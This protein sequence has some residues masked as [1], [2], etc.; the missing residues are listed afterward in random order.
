MRSRS[1]FTLI[2]LLVVMV[3]ISI[4]SAFLLPALGGA[5]ERARRT[6]CA[7]NLKQIGVALHSYSADFNEAYPA[8]LGALFPNY[9]DD[10]RVFDCPSTSTTGSESSPEFTYTQPSPTTA[11]NVVV[12][13]DAS[14]N[15]SAG[16][17]QV[18][19]GG[20]VEWNSGI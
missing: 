4:L 10:G 1:A 11:S 8:T 13:Q 9:I 12:A 7:N 3:I 16:S 20:T 6:K 17:N 19:F 2:E 14:G 5:R 18:L 15:H